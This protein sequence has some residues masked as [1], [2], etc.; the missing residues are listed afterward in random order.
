MSSDVISNIYLLG[1]AMGVMKESGIAFH[2]PTTAYTST[3]AVKH[4]DPLLDID[5]P[6]MKELVKKVIQIL[7]DNCY[8]DFNLAETVCRTGSRHSVDLDLALARMAERAIALGISK[9]ADRYRI[10]LD[11]MY[12]RYINNVAVSYLEDHGCV[13]GHKDI[14]IYGR[15]YL[16]CG[17]LIIRRML[18]WHAQS[19]L[20]DVMTELKVLPGVGIDYMN[21]ADRWDAMNGV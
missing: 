15:P 7:G 11:D 3:K 9:Q 5:D 2:E 10:Y 1:E 20:R 16:Q 13:V 6:A 19:R 17:Q 8:S 4:L 12:P 14:N 18:E 21:A